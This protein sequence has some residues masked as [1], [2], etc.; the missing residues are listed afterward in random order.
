MKRLALCLLTFVWL[1]G[2]N[3]ALK[4]YHLHTVVLPSQCT[5]PDPMVFSLNDD[6]WMVCFQI[7]HSDYTSPLRCLTV[8]QLR[9]RVDIQRTN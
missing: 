3:V 2:C 9:E 5:Q 1:A 7:E 8:R 6:D 4:P